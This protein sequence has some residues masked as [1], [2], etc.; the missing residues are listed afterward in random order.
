VIAQ[1]FQFLLQFWRILVPWYVLNTEE[2]GFVR[3]LGVPRKV[4]VAGLHY[5]HPIIEQLEFED[6]RI[7]CVVGDPQSLT[8]KDGVELVLRPIAQC[9]VVDAEKYLLN[10]CDGR[11]NIQELIAGQLSWLVRRRTAKE[12]KSGMILTELVKRTAKAARAWGI[13]IETIELLDTA[14][15]PSYRLWQSQLNSSGSE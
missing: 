1:I 3:R 15:A 6:G 5:K 14:S 12:V 9:S 4:A 2:V 10:V 13:H 8:S 11:T 7:Y